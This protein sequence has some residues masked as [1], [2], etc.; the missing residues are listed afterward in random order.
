MADVSVWHGSEDR[1]SWS[2]MPWASPV[3][4]LSRVIQIERKRPVPS[5]TSGGKQ[6]R[7]LVA[8]F[9][10]RS[11]LGLSEARPFEKLALSDA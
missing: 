4:L 2:I 5:N 10:L 7:M 1:I 11:P 9:W 6:E 8:I 3:T